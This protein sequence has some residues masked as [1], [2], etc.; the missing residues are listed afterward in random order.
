V[1]DPAEEEDPKQSRRDEKKKRR[2]HPSLQELAKARDEKT[3][4]SRYHIAGAAL[5]THDL[6]LLDSSLIVEDI[7]T[8]A[9]AGLTGRG[10]L[11]A[12]AEK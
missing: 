12:W 5:T 2:K 9:R 6:I 7:E 11:H 8:L 1:A 4:E 3:C 10:G